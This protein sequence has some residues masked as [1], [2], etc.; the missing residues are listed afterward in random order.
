MKTPQI[1]GFFIAFV[2]V[3]AAHFFIV[4]K[5]LRGLNGSKYSDRLRLNLMLAII[6]TAAILLFSLP[7]AAALGYGIIIGFCIMLPLALWEKVWF[8][9]RLNGAILRYKP[10]HDNY[11]RN[12]FLG[13][14]FVFGFQFLFRAMSSGI[15][16]A[17]VVAVGVSWI[18][19]TLI[20]MLRLSHLEARLGEPVIE[21]SSIDNEGTHT[22]H[23]RRARN[24]NL[25]GFGLAIVL[26]SV[27]PAFK[28]R[29]DVP[30]PT[31][32]VM[33]TSN[34]PP[35]HSSDIIVYYNVIGSQDLVPLIAVM[36][37][38]EMNRAPLA[39]SIRLATNEQF[40]AVY[41]ND[42]MIQA[43]PD[44]FVL[45]AI[46]AGQK[47]YR[48]SVPTDFARA[49]FQRDADHTPDAIMAFWNKY[50]AWQLKWHKQ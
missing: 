14:S 8:S 30:N 1:I 16:C 28:W 7:T 39:F 33:W 15:R 49:F 18:G 44:N 34:L 50:V 27:L 21:E 35:D 32:S 40:H 38:L 6:L 41:L 12:F 4:R 20:A 47:P 11:T 45:Y 5:K 2:G 17:Y 25:I 42:Q 48:I 3:A 26:I 24:T 23:D 13:I 31:S 43:E 36:W 9:P 37:Q 19:A 10:M 46:T 22:T 29:A